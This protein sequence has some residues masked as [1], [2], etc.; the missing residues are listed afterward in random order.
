MR[1]TLRKIVAALLLT[2]AAAL[3]AQAA[4]I[5]GTVRDAAT[6]ETLPGVVVKVQNTPKAA[7]TDADGNY[8]ITGLKAGHYVVVA[9]YL[10]YNDGKATLS[11]GSQD[12]TANF[13][14]KS[15]EHQLG[16]VT[17]T[18]VTKKN[19]LG[20]SV[21][22]MKRSLVI[23]NNVS[24]QEISRSQDSN[25][26]EVIKR[27]PGVS[28]IDGKFV[29]VR[30]LSQRYNN[31]WINGGAAP[32]SE[33]DTRAFSFDL[34]PSQQIDNLSIIKVPD[35]VYPADYTGGF[36]IIN[37][38]DIPDQNDMHITLGGSWNT[39]TSFQDFD[40]GKGSGT[41]FLGFDGG[42]RELDGG[43]DSQLATLNDA[44]G[45]D[46]LGN[47]LNNDWHV[48][49]RKP[50]ADLKFTWDLGHRWNL[51]SGQRLG[52]IA[53]V[54]YSNEY[55]TYRNMVNDLFGVYDV[56]HDAPVYLRHAVD[57]QYNHNV[58]LGAMA[59]LTWLSASGNHKLQLKNIFN[60]LGNSR[61][62][63][64]EG[65][66]AQSNQVR[67]AEYYYRSRT[68]YSG[69]LTGRHQLGADVLDWSA[70]YAYANRHIPDRR[71]YRL[72]DALQT[73]VFALSAANDVSREWTQL[74]EH[75]GSLAVNNKL[76]F[77]L[78]SLQPSLLTGAY[79]EYRSRT[80]K[81]R[82]FIYNW[83]ANNNTL[84]SGFRTLPMPELLSDA[85]NFGADK[86]YLLELVRYTDRYRGKRWLGAGYVT[87]QVPVSILDIN[88]GVRFE[89]DD[90]ELIRNLRDYE[91]SE[92]GKHYRHN[93]FF[94]TV[95]L[96][97]HATA[98]Q[99]VR[100]SYGR[101]VNRPEF[102]EL[103]PSVFH[104]FDLDSD[105]KGNVDLKDCYVDNVDLR[106][107]WYPAH[108]E[109]VS[110]AAFYK[111]F[112]DPIEWTYTVA[113]GTD[114]V[115]SYDNALSANN[116]GLEL[117]VK[118]DLA[119][120]GL[121]NFSLAF[122]GSLIHSRVKFPAGS[123][124]HDRAMQGQSPYLVNTGLFYNNEA[125]GLQASVLYNRIGKRIIGVGRTEGTTASGESAKVPDS[126]EMPRNLIDL[127]LA[128]KLGQH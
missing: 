39:R 115:Y 92:E 74:D 112:K 54:N 76:P 9:S 124:E 53:V 43:I 47:G 102:R 114:L 86:L 34:I 56:V 60:Q 83:D 110:L 25:A 42:L 10:G 101:T 88:A 82:E 123:R 95:N 17:V 23:E 26:G 113:G 21:A 41:D 28:I 121:Q 14:L 126:Y 37:T 99:Q 13:D 18:G 68:T 19:T 40:Y 16:E 122:N 70:G 96:T 84:P 7:I 75:I 4:D 35:A 5:T 31:V 117:D 90:M 78:G 11:L 51:E 36:I 29:M 118:K 27:V 3:G 105:V 59:N 116:Y 107:E 80:Y 79:G 30:G 106:Y 8:K 94:P 103:S 67:S 6:H 85:N 119:F 2:A 66:D 52:L 33:A 77:T 97:L 58:R 12:V 49:S 120:M 22:Q 98:T 48:K 109:V 38:K 63:W 100:L 111:H 91:Q 73:D 55:R 15:A 50:W 44:G 89:H 93:D 32:S 81:T 125:L 64:R 1:L 108:G 45:I 127:S 71:R 104:D 20:G 62:T 61:Y 46:L 72:D 57:D 128:K 69:Q 24:A 65:F 87:V